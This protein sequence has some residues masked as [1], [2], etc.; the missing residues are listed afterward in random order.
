[1]TPEERSQKIEEMRER[2]KSTPASVQLSRL[3]WF[4]THCFTCEEEVSFS[5]EVCKHCGEALM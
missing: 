4:Q 3:M 2:L 5:A 1:M